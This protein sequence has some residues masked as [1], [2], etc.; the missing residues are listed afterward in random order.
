MKIVD[1]K[2]ILHPKYVTELVWY[3]IFVVKRCFYY[4]YYYYYYYYYFSYFYME[5]IVYK[6]VNI[7]EGPGNSFSLSM[8]DYTDVLYFIE[9]NGFVYF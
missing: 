3:Q 4:H 7:L 9:S 8:N 5:S 6:Y 2:F 1:N